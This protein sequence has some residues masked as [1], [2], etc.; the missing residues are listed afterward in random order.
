MAF[1]H[2][3]ETISLRGTET[4]DFQRLTYT[5]RVRHGVAPIDDYGIVLAQLS[6]LPDLVTEKAR[7]Y[8]SDRLSVRATAFILFLYRS[9]SIMQTFDHRPQTVDPFTTK[10]DD[11]E[12]MRCYDIVIRMYELLQAE[13][14]HRDRVTNLL[15][16][17]GKDEAQKPGKEAAEE[18][19]NANKMKIHVEEKKKDGGAN[20]PLTDNETVCSKGTFDA[21]KLNILETNAGF[22]EIPPSSTTTISYNNIPSHTESLQKQSSIRNFEGGPFDLNPCRSIITLFNSS[23]VDSMVNENILSGLVRQPS[24]SNNLNVCSMAS[25]GTV[26][27]FPL[28]HELSSPMQMSITTESSRST[29]YEYCL[30]DDDF[31]PF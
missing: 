14:F 29:L 28:A 1:S 5:H 9:S 20:D 31:E 26:L 25:P 23:A 21:T 2:Y 30:S 12:I 8:A 4:D 24:A 27:S 15:E 18:G 10:S 7:R 16:R 13:K 6:G 19:N 11:S 17:I 3:M 22:E